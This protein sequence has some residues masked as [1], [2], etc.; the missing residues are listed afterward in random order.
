VVVGRGVGMLQAEGHIEL[1]DEGVEG[2]I[3]VGNG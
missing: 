3:G 2:G 1:V